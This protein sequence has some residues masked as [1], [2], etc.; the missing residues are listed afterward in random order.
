MFNPLRFNPIPTFLGV[1]FNRTS[2]CTWHVSS[3]KAKVFPN[4]KIFFISALSCRVS[5][6]SLSVLCEA[7]LWPV[8]TYA[9]SGWFPFLTVTCVTDGTPSPND[10]SHY[11]GCLSFFT[12]PFLWGFRAPPGH[13][14]SEP[15]VF[16]PLF[17]FQSSPNMKWDQGFVSAHLF[18]NLSSRRLF[19][20]A[21][22][23]RNRFPL[24]WCLLFSLHALALILFSPVDGLAELI[25]LWGYMVSRHAFIF[26]RGLVTTTGIT[27]Y[28]NLSMVTSLGCRKKVLCSSLPC[29]IALLALD[30]HKASNVDNSEAGLNTSYKWQAY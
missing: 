3:L 9:S 13:L 10:R 25:D 28:L 29:M 14:M 6:K 16:Q 18:I 8:L 12:I 1:T 11:H 24:V 26:E 21:I 4:L 20:F 17:L 5:K 27:L 22:P 19:V 30:T 23:L 7:F 2:F 15:F